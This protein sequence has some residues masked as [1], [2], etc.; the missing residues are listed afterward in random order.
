MLL[1][2]PFCFELPRNCDKNRYV[3]DT[4]LDPLHTEFQG[5][6]SRSVRNVWDGKNSAPGCTPICGSGSGNF[7]N[8]ANGHGSHVAGTVGGQTVGVAP[9]ASILG[10]KVLGDDGLGSFGVMIQAIDWVGT[11]AKKSGKPSVI[12]MSISGG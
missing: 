1:R 7:N 2:R 5:G 12:T 8:D 6:S 10:V 4:G 9:G 11:N 3:L